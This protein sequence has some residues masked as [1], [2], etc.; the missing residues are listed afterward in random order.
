MNDPLL[1][2]QLASYRVLQPLGQGSFAQVYLGQHIHLDNFVAIKVL[3]AQLGEQEEKDFRSEA[4][5][6]VKLKNAHIVRLL[7]YGIIDNRPFLVTELAK[8]GSL[9]KIYPHGTRLPLPEIA[10][11]TTQIAEALNYAHEQN[12]VHRDVKPENILVGDN[13]ELLLADFGI[14]KLLGTS[15]SYLTGRAA[16]TLAYMAPEQF[17][18][19]GSPASDQYAVGVMVYEWLTGRFPFVGTAAE[20]MGQHLKNPPLPISQFNPQVSP[21]VEW[22]VQIALKKE[23][24]QRF[25]NLLAFAQ[26]LRQAAQVEKQQIANFKVPKVLR[27]SSSGNIPLPSSNPVLSNNMNYVPVAPIVQSKPALPF[28]TLPSLPPAQLTDFWWPTFVI[29]AEQRR[30]INQAGLPFEQLDTFGQLPGFPSQPVPL[31]VSHAPSPVSNGSLQNI[32]RISESV[33]PN[34]NIGSGVT[35]PFPNVG[36]NVSMPQV[37][38]RVRVAGGQQSIKRSTGLGGPLPGM[39]PVKPTGV[40][41]PTAQKSANSW[42]TVA[43]ITLGIA[44]ICSIAAGSTTYYSSAENAIGWSW[45]LVLVSIVT[46]ITALVK[47][48]NRTTLITWLVI[49]LVVALLMLGINSGIQ[50]HISSYY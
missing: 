22:A 30:T 48:K 40:R 5:L 32:Q 41:Q 39:P 10:A 34:I 28:T 18:G 36:V 35:G 45:F 21:D 20:V 42:A 27:H 24:E 15:G 47:A 9:H 16:G 46:N 31:P 2:R 25:R 49:F 3:H 19:H 12:I 23:P 6:L 43:M 13:D 4:L 8:K 14:A 33:R 11:Y 26:A 37:S 50:S 7:D 29:S 1:G 44:I 17:M 38:V